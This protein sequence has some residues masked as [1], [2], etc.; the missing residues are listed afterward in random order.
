[1]IREHLAGHPYDFAI[2]SVHAGPDSPYLPGRVT[3]WLAGKTI[4]E[5]LAP[6]FD[7]VEAAIRSGLF[8]VL[9]HLDIVK[10]YV[11]PTIPPAAFGAAPE[12]YEPILRALVES[13]TGLEVNASGLRQSPGEP[14]P[15]PAV[16]ARFRELGGERVTA[17]SDAHLAESF[18][19]GL[20]AAYASLAWAG[21]EALSFRRAAGGPAVPIAMPARLRR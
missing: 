17:G 18:A 6:Y 9:G 14:Y 13:G 19:Y 2:G 4:T 15:P 20:G 12:L 21:F 3:R 7:E 11:A 16:V 5:A 10:R 1:V 8:D